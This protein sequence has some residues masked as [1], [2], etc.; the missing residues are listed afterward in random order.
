MAKTKEQKQRKK[1]IEL[2]IA[3]VI[4]IATGLLGIMNIFPT[5]SPTYNSS[6]SGQTS[7]SQSYSTTSPILNFS[8]STTSSQTTTSQ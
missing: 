3:L 6:Q 2:A 8:S 4:I 1:E 5:Q 7:V